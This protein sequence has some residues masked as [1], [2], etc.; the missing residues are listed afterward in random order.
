MIT[1]LVE[2]GCDDCPEGA[3]DDPDGWRDIQE[4]NKVDVVV[5]SIA[6]GWNE[7]L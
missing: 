2:S 3:E 5:N 6:D 7:K 4:A 1:D